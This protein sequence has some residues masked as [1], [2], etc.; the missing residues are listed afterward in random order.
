VPNLD[1]DLPLDLPRFPPEMERLPQRRG[2]ASQPTNVQF[3]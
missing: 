2:A 1:A 3:H